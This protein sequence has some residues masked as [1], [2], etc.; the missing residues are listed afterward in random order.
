[1]LA[2]KIAVHACVAASFL[3]V[4]A[5]CQ[6]RN[7]PSTASTHPDDHFLGTWKLE[8]D[9]ATAFRGLTNPIPVYELIRISRDGDLYTLAFSQQS[10][11]PGESER[12]LVGSMQTP[13]VGVE[14]V[15]GKLGTYRAYFRR[16]DA[17]TFNQGSE[18]GE[19]QYRVQTDQK[20]MKVRQQPYLD[21]G[22]IRELVYDKV[23]NVD[24]TPF[25][26]F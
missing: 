26:R 22:F 15:H 10:E 24:V 17:D 9:K 18:L 3:L 23:P 20:A 14:L 2:R 13:G 25:P 11:Q 1:M 4:S 5:S 8:K 21:N 16:V 7:P 6:K 19:T 12:V